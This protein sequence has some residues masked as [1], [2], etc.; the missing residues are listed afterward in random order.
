MIS[1]PWTD[2]SA[3]NFI[4]ELTDA[5]N[6]SCR[7]CFKKRTDIFRSVQD[8]ERDLDVGLRLRPAHTVTLSG[9]E[10]TLHPDLSRIIEIVKRRGVHVFMLTN[11]VKADVFRL[12]E[13]KSKGLDSILFHVEPGQDRPDLTDKSDTNPVEARLSEL[14]EMASSEG[15][16]VSVSVTLYEDD[17]QT[18][19]WITRFVFESPEVGFLFLSK[20][21]DLCNLPTVNSLSRSTP[22]WLSIAGI[23]ALFKEEYG[24]QPFSYIPSNGERK[25][26][27]ISYFVPIAYRGNGR[28]YYK[29]QS[30]AVDRW[31]M[32]LQRLITGRFTHK[33]KQSK[34]LTFLRTT[35]NGVTTLRFASLLGFLRIFVFGAAHAGHKIIA[36]DDGPAISAN[37]TIE[38][39]TYCPTAVVRGSELLACCVADRENSGEQSHDSV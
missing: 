31:L 16:D 39:C 26:C 17:P 38:C 23:E 7:S 27:W 13:W 21:T 5:C 29:Y 11:G 25:T 32:R 9:G 35:I 4:L 10:P 20:G 34:G 12:R 15:L 33:L 24:I 14:V 18:L 19:N 8:I 30:N 36:Y 1:M 37:G 2:G 22:S 6:I 28:T 3:P